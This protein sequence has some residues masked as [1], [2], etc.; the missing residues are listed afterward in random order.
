M[1]TRKGAR[2]Q[3]VA[4]QRCGGRKGLG[5][6]GQRSGCREHRRCL[7]FDPEGDR[8]PSMILRRVWL[9][10]CFTKLILAALCRIIAVKLSE[11]G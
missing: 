5:S 2:K 8:V 4:E 1:Q 6:T 10:L 9:K 11:R 3:G 7:E